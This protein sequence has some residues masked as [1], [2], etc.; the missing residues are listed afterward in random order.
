M[1][2]RRKALAR[3]ALGLFLAAVGVLGAA[4]T[5]AAQTGPNNAI[6]D[7]PGIRVGHSTRP[8]AATGTTAFVF[9]T[10]ALMGVSPS[11]GAP[12][13][14]LATLLTAQHQDSQRVVMHGLVLS[15]GSIYG[16][17][18][19]CGV[20]RYLDEEGF[21][22]GGRAHVPGAIIFDL[23]RGEID[24]PPGTGSNPCR[25]GYIAASTA[26]TGA[27]Q[28]GSVGAG[29][30]ARAGGLKSGLGTASTVLPDGTVVGALVV[31]NAAGRVYNDLSK[32]ELY[33]LW[34]EQDD[35]FGRVRPP[36][37]GCTVNPALPEAKP[38]E[39]TTI[40]VIATSAPLTAGQTERL[41]IVTNDGLARAVRPAH[42]TG[43]GDTVFAVTTADDPATVEQSSFVESGGPF[44]RILA[45]AADTYARAIT[46]AIINADPAL[47]ETY[48]ERFPTACPGKKHGA[49]AAPAKHV[50]PPAAPAP[51]PEPAAT[52]GALR[53]LLGA[54]LAVVALGAALLL[55][56]FGRRLVRVARR[57]STTAGSTA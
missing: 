24:A 53:E 2:A 39:N 21:Q 50:A 46:H 15:G 49:F 14:R 23:N 16:L 45:A 34:L 30:G 38:G 12:G 47:G 54:G 19:A 44:S 41:A 51:A 1:Q 56:P 26:R 40:G 31:V 13:T 20:V 28:E 10:G 33:T 8:E 18:T 36:R 35:E 9:P 6:T 3:A 43:D 29:T 5:A 42:A 22:Y 7:V 57:R 48:C 52:P 55:T 11:G 17:D 4:S 32:C 27:V 25:D 37:Q